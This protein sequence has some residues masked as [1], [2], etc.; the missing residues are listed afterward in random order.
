MSEDVTHRLKEVLDSVRSLV[1]AQNFTG[2]CERLEAECEA[3]IDEQ[4]LSDAASLTAML[5]SFRSMTGDEEAAL[6]ALRKAEEL[7]P[8]NTHRSIDTATH[9]FSRMGLAADATV[10][11]NRALDAPSLDTLTKHQALALLGNI[12]VAENQIDRAAKLLSEAEEA[13]T[14]GN[15]DAMFWDRALPNA[16]AESRWVR[17]A[18]RNYLTALATRAELESDEGTAS[19][20]GRILAKL[21]G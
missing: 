17:D 12:A 10:I 3:A 13:A 5:G 19:E 14:S 15:L 9:L 6:R 1:R 18:T 8:S 2:V 20:V 16:L 11:A 7:E 4:R 21:D